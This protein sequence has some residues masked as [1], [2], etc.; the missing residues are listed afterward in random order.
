M[1]NSGK[2]AAGKDQT[3]GLGKLKIRCNCPC[4]L[5]WHLGLSKYLLKVIDHEVVLSITRALSLSQPLS[6]S[7]TISKELHYPER[8]YFGQD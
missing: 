4:Q 6:H 3:A 5:H 2:K 1:K 7:K 8:Q